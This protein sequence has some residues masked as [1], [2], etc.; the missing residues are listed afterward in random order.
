MSGA[1][2]ITADVRTAG[3]AE[4]GSTQTSGSALLAREFIRFARLST[5]R[6]PRGLSS[7]ELGTA[8]PQGSVAPRARAGSDPRQLAE[9]L[10]R[11]R[12][13]EP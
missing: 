13:S 3:E 9:G 7:V 2:G 5:D 6:R 11:L 8:F 12:V 4:N 1:A 10:A